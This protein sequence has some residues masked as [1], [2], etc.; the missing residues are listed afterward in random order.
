MV[1]G[2]ARF[3]LVSSCKINHFGINPE[4]G[5]RPPRESR[6]IKVIT[7]RR[8]DLTVEMAIELILVESKSLK[9]RKVVRVIIIYKERLSLVRLGE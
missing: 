8:G 6:V 7:V 9:R 2:I 5:G 3:C 4:S 1:A